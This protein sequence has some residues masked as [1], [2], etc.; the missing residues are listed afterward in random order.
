MIDHSPPRLNHKKERANLTVE[1]N[2]ENT[3]PIIPVS[4]VSDQPIG[5]ESTIMTGAR[6]LNST[7]SDMEKAIHAAHKEHLISPPDLISPKGVSPQIELRFDS[8]QS[9]IHLLAD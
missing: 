4:P 2:E 8:D 1:I 3:L 6:S 7:D 5:F 9:D